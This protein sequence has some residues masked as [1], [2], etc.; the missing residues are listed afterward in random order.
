MQ[1]GLESSPGSKPPAGKETGSKG[2]Q[3]D[4]TRTAQ[5]RLF[6][7]VQVPGRL[8]TVDFVKKLP[9]QCP[10]QGGQDASHCD[11]PC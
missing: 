11:V 8:L 4:H 10:A 5:T 1:L 2:L 3:H 9:L 7:I 6:A